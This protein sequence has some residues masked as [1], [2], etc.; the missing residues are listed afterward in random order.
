MKNQRDSSFLCSMKNPREESRMVAAAWRD[1]GCS[2]TDSGFLAGFTGMQGEIKNQDA[3]QLAILRHR[4]WTMRRCSSNIYQL[5][6]SA[7]IRGNALLVITASEI[8]LL[9]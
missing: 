2:K 3:L 8:L 5:K 6:T 4:Q 9:L 7:S 1:V